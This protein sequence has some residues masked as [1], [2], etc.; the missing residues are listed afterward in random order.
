MTT[1]EIIKL[2]TALGLPFNE[3]TNFP[4]YLAKNWVVFDGCNGQRFM[5]RGEWS[6][7]K[8]LAKLGKALYLYGQREKC[9]E[10]SRVISITSD[11]EDV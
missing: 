2:G 7:D 5:I 9:L 10:I 11:N 6:D 3:K 4:D 8:I 1:K